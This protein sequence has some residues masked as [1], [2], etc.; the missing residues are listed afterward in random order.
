[1]ISSKIKIPPYTCKDLDTGHVDHRP[2]HQNYDRYIYLIDL[3]RK[4]DY[5]EDNIFK[6]IPF[7]VQD[8]L[9]NTI[10]IRSN[11]AMIVLG[12]MIG[13]DVQQ[14]KAW[15][16]KAIAAMNQKLWNHGTGMYDAYDMINNQRI[17]MEASS[18]LMPLLGGISD[19]E[20]SVN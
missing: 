4:G 9:F 17:L 18:G 11:K 13:E 10:L 3:F 5:R 2:T 6:I 19:S 14:F 8:L 7:S 20:Q 1:M 12:D 16:V 15:N